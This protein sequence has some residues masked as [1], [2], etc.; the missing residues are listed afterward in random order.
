MAGFAVKDPS[1][2]IVHPYQWLAQ[3]D[4][5]GVST[6]GGYYSVCV[7]NQFSRFSEKLVNLYITVIKLVKLL[8]CIVYSPCFYT[9]YTRVS[10]SY[11]H[12]FAGGGHE[13]KSC[14]M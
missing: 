5:Q 7:D 2:A 12:T 6:S 14:K 13:I 4:Y 9:S 3:S 8:L 11:L 10:S 1:G